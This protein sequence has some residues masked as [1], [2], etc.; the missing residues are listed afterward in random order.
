MDFRD[1]NKEQLDSL[2]PEER[3][4]A[5]EILEQYA[6]KGSS[7]IFNE[8]VYSDYE[9]IPVDIETFLTDD[10]YMGQAWKDSENKLKIY[11]YWMKKLK[12][13]FPTPFD[14]KVNNFIASGA[15]GLG[16]SEICVAIM[17]YL[18]YRIMCLK[19]P[20]EYYHMKPTEKIVF[21]FMN[22]K[23]DLAEE[24][25]NSK[26]QN[27]IKMSPWFL[28]RGS[29]TG[30]YQ[31][32]W[33]PDSKYC[34]DIKIGSQSDD[35]IGLPCY[36]IFF[37]EI[38]FIRNQNIDIQKQKAIDMIDTAIGGMMTRFVHNGKNPTLLMLASSKRSEKSFLEEHIKT[39]LA[40]EP[41]NV[42]IVDEPVWI[43]KPKGTYSNKTFPLAVGNKF[44]V[45]QVLK[46]DEDVS[47]YIQ[48]GYRIIYPPVDLKAQFLDDM[49]RAL[50]DFAGIS[51]TQLSKYISG[52]AVKDCIDKELQNPFTKEI[53]EVGNGKDDTLEYKDFFDISKVP[54]T[55]KNKPLYVHLDMSISGDMTGISGV[56]IKGKKPSS[57]NKNQSKDLFFQL[58]FSVSVKAPKGRQISFEKNRNF[59]RW[60]REQEFNVREISTDTFQSY[61][62]RQQLESEGFVCSVQSVDR[63]ESNSHV[64]IPYQ[65]LK[66]VIYEQRVA[67]F[68]D[69]SLIE[70]LVNLERDITSGKIDHPASFRKD[71]ADSFCGALFTASKYAEEYA[72]NY[73][74][75]YDAFLGA[76]ETEEL[77]EEE[78]KKQLMVDFE[79]QLKEFGISNKPPEQT[80][81]ENENKNPFILNDILIW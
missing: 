60:L 50:C 7:D 24:I 80:K 39:K 23:L 74:E 38:S 79:E 52:E 51:S 53:I 56:W 76:N 61:D 63:V 54:T 11:P 13:L 37:D 5:L 41:E 31:K 49:D 47:E 67:M 73:G 1:I 3:K 40:S 15:R 64:C 27:S 70:E 62:L 66:N 44:L 10:S 34:V 45:S 20:L 43:V 33:E 22:I 25:A 17:C 77:R 35:L 55:M 59:I 72:Y 4:L 12:E 18:L 69:N 68:E 2:S 36:A 29:I 26:F 71:A 9:E 78:K 19:N 28:K 58:A 48:K 75:D 32:Y 65:F 81:Q 30:R 46:D 8:L 42:M 16:K 21:A 14:T 6:K 57:D